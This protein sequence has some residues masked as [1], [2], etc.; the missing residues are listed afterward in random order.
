[1]SKPKIVV[2]RMRELIYTAIFALLIITLLLLLF[3]MFHP[4]ESGS[5][6]SIVHTG[7]LYLLCVCI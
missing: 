1:M 2:L 3:L 6:S 5:Q 4:K 7:H